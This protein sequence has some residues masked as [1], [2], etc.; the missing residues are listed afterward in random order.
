MGSRGLGALT[1][2]LIARI[3]GFTGPMGAAERDLDKRTRAMEKR[4]AAFS[5]SITSAFS[6]MALKLGGFLGGFF[7]IQ[8]GIDGF[9]SSIDRADKMRDLSIQLGIGV[10]NL[11]ALAYAA[12][13]S[14]VE[15]DDFATSLK[16]LEKN[17]AAAL[18]PKSKQRG[19][20]DAILGK[21]KADLQDTEA[22]LRQLADA[23]SKMEDTPTR[24]A[25]ELEIFGKSGL[26]MAEFLKGGSTEI[27]RL[28]KRAK[29]LGVTIDDETADSADRFND[30]LADVKAVAAG[31]GTQ[32][33]T[34][35][36]PQVED[37]LDWMVEFGTDPGNVEKLVKD[38]TSAFNNLASAI[39]D[40]GKFGA[41]IY[42]VLDTL[43]TK[44][45]ALEKGGQKAAFAIWGALA[46]DGGT[47]QRMLDENQRALNGEG[48]IGLNGEFNANAPTR[49]RA[50]LKGRGGPEK[51]QPVEVDKEAERRIAAFMAGNTEATNKNAEAKRKAAEAARAQK[52]REEELAKAVKM[53]AEAQ[54]EFDRQLE[55]LIAQ[56]GGPLAESSLKYRREEEE[57]RKL[58]ETG[59]TPNAEKLTEALNALHAARDADAGAIR[60]QLDTGGEQLKQ[61]QDELDLLNLQTGAERVRAAFF[62]DNPTATDS[63]ADAAVRISS[64]LTETR[65]LI[66]SMDEFRSSAAD[67]FM[68]FTDGISAGIEGLKD[69]GDAFANQLQRMASEYLA[70]ALFG[71]QGTTGGGL[72]GNILSSIFGGASSSGAGFG[73]PL[74]GSGLIPGFANGTNN[75]PGGL[76]WVGERGREL[77]NLPKGSQVIPNHRV[78]SA[79]GITQN[80]AFHLGA[81]TD[82]RTQQQ[83]AAKVGYQARR[84]QA[85]N[86]ATS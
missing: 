1:L 66:D 74:P 9:F 83:I 20:F 10:D 11:S 16:F 29:E 71:Q 82:V 30:K 19:L 51:P 35:L 48:S 45:T 47:F 28:T 62:L 39:S 13:Q 73:I 32:L 15:L 85:R 17:A 42:G 22:L 3:G 26:K 12:Q 8:K 25:L 75:A 6:G 68:S 65:K 72:F 4:A 67:A 52:E 64:Q 18:D 58:W 7:A 5:K 14:G 33:A 43:Q 27:E 34:A 84:A 63:Q 54:V 78:G 59:S 81:P 23:F 24:A 2:D 53:A 69:F 77:V 44:L 56:R 50:R 21:G 38:T 41:Q 86:G 40:V 55:D 70:S 57:L 49:T 37:L 80:V 61:M 79:G 36:M 60:K 31:L 76:A 46:P